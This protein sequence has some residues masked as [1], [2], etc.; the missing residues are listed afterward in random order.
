MKGTG[1]FR[2]MNISSAGL[3][4]QRMKLDAIA[5]NLANAETTRTEEGGPYRRKSV[6]ISAGKESAAPKYGQGDFA[7]LL[8][9]YMEHSTAPV[10]I[11]PPVEIPVGTIEIDERTPFM[12]HFDPDH[13]DADADG[14][15]RMPNVNVIDEMVDM[16]TAT[17]AYEANVT[18]IQ[19]AKNMFLK[20]LE[21]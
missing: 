21:I 15:V 14:M 9:G 13:P 6:N 20:A 17:R 10:L 7:G 2:A 5:E 3:T 16:V 12:L 11:D 8:A 1:I 4:V 18:A 19:S